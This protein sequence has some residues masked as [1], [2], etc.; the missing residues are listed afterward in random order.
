MY[1]RCP[2]CHTVHPVNAALLAGGGGRYRCGKCN[3]VSNALESLFDEWPDAG[4]RAPAAGEMPVLGL[5]LDLAAADALQAPADDAGGPPEEAAG[6]RRANRRTRLIRAAWI[7]AA[8]VILIV[9]AF[10]VAEFQGV[11]LPER[12]GTAMALL[13]PGP[14]TAPVDDSFR[15]LDRI[16][17]VSRELTSHPGQPGRLRLSATIVN[18]ASRSQPYPDL[19]ILLLDAG[20]QVVASQRF[21]PGDYLA[22]DRPANAKMAPHAYLPLAL[23]LEDPGEQAVG[24]ELRFH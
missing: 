22:A 21:V 11:P 3:K 4:A 17:L 10:R 16:H 19:E 9:V 18:R 14:Q 12:I 20:G 5:S 6:S 23:D 24:F 15:D 2:G 7:T 13:R 8:I 1:T